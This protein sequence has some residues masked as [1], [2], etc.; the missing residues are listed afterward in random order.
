M[1]V[2]RRALGRGEGSASERERSRGGTGR[3]RDAP[4]GRVGC[5]RPEAP[6][7]PPTDYTPGRRSFA[8]AQGVRILNFQLSILAGPLQSQKQSP[9]VQRAREGGWGERKPSPGK[10]G[11]QRSGRGGRS[12]RRAGSQPGGAA[13]RSPGA[14]TRR[15]AARGSQRPGAHSL[16]LSGR[17]PARWPPRRG[18]PHARVWP[19]PTRRATCTSRPPRWRSTRAPHTA[20]ASFRGP[21]RMSSAALLRAPHSRPTLAPLPSRLPRRATT[22][23][24]STVPIPRL[25]PPPPSRT[26]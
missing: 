19:C 24:S 12:R 18:A 10:R 15:A 4:G 3:G 26:W 6:A 16:A 21:A 2:E 17:R 22:R 14:E 20:P 13:G 8:R 23:T 7:S 11:A 1:A 5:R 9:P 25:R